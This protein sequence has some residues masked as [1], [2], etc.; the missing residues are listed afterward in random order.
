MP[1]IMPTGMLSFPA[2]YGQQ[3]RFLLVVQQNQPDGS[4]AIVFPTI[5]AVSSG[6]VP[7][8]RCERRARAGR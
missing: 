3:A 4:S 1:S 2:E 8:P 6:D 5:A 7:S